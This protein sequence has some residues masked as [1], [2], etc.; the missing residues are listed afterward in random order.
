[1]AVNSWVF[2]G[3]TLF[4]GILLYPYPYHYG[5]STTGL[6]GLIDSLLSHFNSSI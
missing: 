1:M 3:I 5:Y 2:V 6:K 4:I